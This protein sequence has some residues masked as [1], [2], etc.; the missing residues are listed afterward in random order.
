[1]A[2]CLPMPLE[3]PTIRAKNAGGAVI[4]LI[5][6]LPLDLLR[7]TRRVAHWLSKVAVGPTLPLMRGL[8]GGFEGRAGDRRNSPGPPPSILSSHQLP[9]PF[10]VGFEFL[11]FFGLGLEFGLF[12]G[13]H[14]RRG[15]GQEVFV[16][17]FAL[18]L[19]DFF[20]QFLQFPVQALGLFGKV[21]D[22]GQGH[23]DVH[24]VH[25]GLGRGRGG[26]A[27]GVAVEFLDPAQDLDG[28]PVAVKGLNGP[29]LGAVEED[30]HLGARRHVHFA[31]DIAD[32]GD[33]GHDQVHLGF[34]LGVVECGVRLGV[35]R[36]HDA[37]LG[38]GQFLPDLLG[39]EGHEGV[40][41]AQDGAEH[42]EE[43]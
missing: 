33:G 27:G 30:L 11:E 31:P 2:V 35:G 13:D 39:D 21:D 16:A 42:L 7:A 4:G 36:H 19:G 28:L 10:P 40:Q 20:A 22:A 5:S 43:D 23:E 15:L 32:G 37:A 12:F 29:G 34:G 6:F 41:E 1:M 8:G 3:P 17:H 9:N 26:A 25:H 18:G 14:F 38:A 24:L